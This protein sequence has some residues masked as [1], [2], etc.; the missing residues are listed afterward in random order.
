M[1]RKEREITDLNE[2]LEIIARNDT[3]RLAFCDKGVPYIV[4]LSFGYRYLNDT[5]TLYF[6]GAAEGRKMDCINQGGTVCFELDDKHSLVTGKTDCQY[7]MAYE[8]LIGTGKITVLT[9]MEEKKQA[10]A[11]IMEHY[12]SKQ[13]FAFDDKVVERVCV[14]KLTVEEFTAKRREKPM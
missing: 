6:H 1:R 9:D 13:S 12:T 5:L 4:P 8:S 3:C 7:S 14:F 2:K 11:C 10:L